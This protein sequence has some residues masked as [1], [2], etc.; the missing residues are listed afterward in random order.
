MEYNG[1][2]RS[3]IKYNNNV[4]NLGLRKKSIETSSI[5]HNLK[6]LS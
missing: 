4:P 3:G 6:Y 2:E 5:V 1:M